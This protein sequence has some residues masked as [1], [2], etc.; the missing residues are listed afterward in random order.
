ML[1]L[2]GTTLVLYG[3]GFLSWADYRSLIDVDLEQAGGKDNT[4]AKGILYGC[5][6]VLHSHVTPRLLA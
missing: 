1:N 3:R 2:I 6:I 5:N 4:H